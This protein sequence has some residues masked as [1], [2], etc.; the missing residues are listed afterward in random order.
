MHSDVSIL[1]NLMAI[2][3]A[4][5]KYERCYS[6]FV[7][8]GSSTLRDPFPTIG[9]DVQLGHSS[10]LWRDAIC[11]SMDRLS[12]LRILTDALTFLLQLHDLILTQRNSR[13]PH[14]RSP[15]DLGRQLNPLVNHL[16]Q[17]LKVPHIEPR[18]HRSDEDRLLVERITEAVGKSNGNSDRIAGFGVDIGTTGRVET[19]GACFDEEVFVVHLV[20]VEHWA[21]GAR[22]DEGFDCRQAHLSSAA[23]LYYSV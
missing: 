17:M 14:H 18:C 13:E 19:H 22:W 7:S 9:R 11:P 10:R 3:V 6:N 1:A 20:E 21:C 23:I 16:F 2:E 4:F 15:I 8:H 12:I 5:P